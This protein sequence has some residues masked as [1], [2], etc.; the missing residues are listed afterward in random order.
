MTAC[1]G[2]LGNLRW[3]LETAGPYVPSAGTGWA[4][5]VPT[6]SDRLAIIEQIDPSGLVHAK[7]EPSRVVQY[8]HEGTEHIPGTYSGSFTV[9]LHLTGHGSA[10][11]GATAMRSLMKFLG[12]VLGNSQVSAATGDT[13]TGGTASVPTT[14]LATGFDAGSLPRIGVFGDG[15]GNGQFVAVGSHAANNLTLKTAIDGAPVNGALLH[16]SELAYVAATTCELQGARFL[17]QSADQQYVTRGCFPMGYRFVGLGP[18]ELPG[19]EVTIGVSY[20][21]PVAETF[22]TT[23]TFDSGSGPF[24]PA[25]NTLGTFFYNSHGTATR[26][27]LT[28]RGMSIESTLAVDPIPGYGGLW[29]GQNIVGARRKS[30]NLY[31]DLEFDAAGA[32]ANPDWYAAWLTGGKKHGLATLCAAAGQ[33]MGFR[34]PCMRIVGNRPTQ[35][36][37]NGFNSVKVRFA[38]YADETVTTDELTLSPLVVAA[39]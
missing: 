19:L 21:A 38:L 20:W 26:N 36:Q 34:F 29:P 2:R 14:T 18:G 11:T 9:K 31:L 25:P 8:M 10:T 7:I 27:L 23:D 22:P 15:D 1:D 3:S 32:S 6:W 16:S 4:E 17:W 30:G 39:A 35:A 28:V 24:N 33:A 13:L 5:D 12:W 37:L